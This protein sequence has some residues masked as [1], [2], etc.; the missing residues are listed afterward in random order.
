MKQMKRP[1]ETGMKPYINQDRKSASGLAEPGQTVTR[2]STGEKYTV[3]SHLAVGHIV[4]CKDK[5]GNEVRLWPSDTIELP[6]YN[7]ETGR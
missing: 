1:A 7:W 3:V 4:Y 5:D 2:R 6:Y